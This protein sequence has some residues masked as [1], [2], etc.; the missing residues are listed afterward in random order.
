MPTSRHRC[1]K[2]ILLFNDL[3]PSFVFSALKNIWL[4]IYR[5]DQ[6]QNTTSLLLLEVEQQRRKEFSS[7]FYIHVPGNNDGLL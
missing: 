4:L 6:L 3:I 7:V 5:Y 1:A 2:K